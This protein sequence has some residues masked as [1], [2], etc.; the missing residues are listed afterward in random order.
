M[1]MFDP[2][3][4]QLGQT[5][6]EEDASKEFEIGYKYDKASKESAYGRA[7]ELDYPNETVVEFPREIIEKIKEADSS[8][9]NDNTE[10]S[11][12]FTFFEPSMNYASL[13]FTYTFT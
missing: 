2:N 12:Y 6:T 7:K 10:L 8:A 9:N 3:A 13:K 1:A 5:G 11:I 4:D